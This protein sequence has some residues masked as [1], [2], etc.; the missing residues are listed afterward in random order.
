MPLLGS[1]DLR[2]LSLPAITLV[3]AG[4]DFF[5]PRAFF[6]LLFLPSLLVHARSRGHTLLFG[7]T[8]VFFSGLVYFLF[9]AAWLN[10]FIVVGE[11][12]WIT[13]LAG[14]AA[15]VIALANIKDIFLAAP[16]DQPV[17]TG[18]SDAAPLPACS[19]SHVR[20]ASRLFSPGY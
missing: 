1:L 18:T 17:L 15:V 8:F 4:L 6:E 13:T 2:S 16:R 11:L 10:L 9:M 7:G 12:M 5:N 19:Q 3:L 20:R 14:L